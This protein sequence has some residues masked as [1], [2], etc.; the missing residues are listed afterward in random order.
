[1][2]DNLGTKLALVS[3]KEACNL[4]IEIGGLKVRVRVDD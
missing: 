1:V 3:E 2:A 4:W